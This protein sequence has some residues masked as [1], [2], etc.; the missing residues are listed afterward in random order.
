MS[1]AIIKGDAPGLPTDYDPEKGLKGVAVAEAA[2][3]YYARAKDRTR[4][5]EAIE[6][7]LGEQRRFVL[8]WDQ[9]N[10][11][12]LG[13]TTVADRRQYP[14]RSTIHRWR[15]RLKDSKKFDATLLAALERCV[16]VGEA[17]QGHSDYAKLTNSGDYEWY[18]P[19]EYIHAAR[20]V[21]GAIDLDP[22]SSDRAQQAVRA[23]RYF[24]KNDDGLKGAWHGRV[25]LNP[26]F[27]QP[28]I[29]EFVAKIVAEHN[30][31]RIDAAIMLTNN[32]TDTG[33]FHEALAASDAICFTRGRIKFYKDEGEKA[34]PLQGQAFFYFGDDVV[35]FVERFSGIGA[36]VG[37]L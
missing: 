28:L 4:L 25:W 8:W 5:Q 27:A 11:N 33:W 37:R 2:E 26:P 34:A 13:N 7:K 21:L 12:S 10:L 23:A 22:A 16:K 1:G 18:T 6:A 15:K 9:Q 36:V 3:K 19:P 29:S 31:G 14:D 20:D 30:A 32:S 17:R 35:G 24:T